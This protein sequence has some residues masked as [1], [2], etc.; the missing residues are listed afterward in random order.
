M[1]PGQRQRTGGVA[2]P[3]LSGRGQRFDGGRGPAEG[4]LSPADGVGT[5]R[6]GPALR[7]G[8]LARQRRELGAETLSPFADRMLG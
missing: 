6:P 3:T 5:G 1:G 2:E 8:D 4:A 7:L